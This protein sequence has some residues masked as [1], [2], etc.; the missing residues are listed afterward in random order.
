[1]EGR[2]NQ[3]DGSVLAQDFLVDQLSQ[4]TE[5][6]DGDSL[7]GYGHTF[8]EGTNLIGQIPGGDRADEYVVLGAHYDHLGRDCPT[9]TPGDDVCNGAGDN[10]SGVATV[11]EVGRLL[12]ADPEPPPRT[13]ILALWDAEEDGLLGSAAYVADPA[14]PLD[15]TVAYLNWDIQGS[16]LSPALADTHRRRRGR[17]RRPEPHRRHRGR[18][19]GVAAG[20]PSPSASC[21]ARAAATTPTSP[22]AGVPIVFFT[23]ANTPCY[24][25]SQDDVSNLDFDKLDQQILTAEALTRD[26]MSTDDLPEYDATAPPA[27]YDDAVSM[28][29]VVSAAQPDFDLFAPRPQA[30]AE[31]FLADLNTMVDA[32]PRRLR[33]RRGQHPPRRLGRHRRGPQHRG[34]RRASS[35]EY[36]SRESP[37]ADHGYRPRPWPST[38]VRQ[39]ARRGA[40]RH[41]AGRPR[42][43]AGPELRAGGRRGGRSAS[44]CSPWPRVAGD[45]TIPPSPTSQGEPAPDFAFEPLDGG[46]DVDFAAF[47]AGRPAR[48][49]LLLQRTAPPASWRCLTCRTPTRPTATGSP[50]S[51]SPTRSRVE[52]GL[53]LVERTGVTYEHRPG[54]RRRASSP[55]TPGS[56]CR[57][58]CS[59]TPTG[60]SPRPTLAPDPP[61]RAAGRAGRAAGVIDAPLA[62]AFTA[63]MVATVNPCGFAMLPAYL[64]FFLGLEG[65]AADED[66]PGRCGPGPGGR[67]RR[68]PGLRRRVHHRSGRSS[69]TCHWPW[70]S[71]SRG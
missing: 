53:D 6:L 58:R 60:R 42:H 41:G 20:R 61:R 71:G 33:R 37:A 31:Q 29:G 21:S 1:M 56:G 49:Q 48:D 67:R 34:V 15:D 52:D 27:T 23:D 70:T 30:T 40:G 44:P 63:G 45:G 24:H 26:L 46:A 50:S 12:A 62:L 66:A 69:P 3:T 55:P 43:G 17:D 9:D 28:L 10:A 51:A 35:T 13:V 19:G 5:P 59:S 4:F 47:R 64:T 8:A 38:R 25:T 16:N 57:P 22:A 14:V 65:G 2:D 18:H 32:G 36:R 7:D 68:D 54:P 11:L 39:P